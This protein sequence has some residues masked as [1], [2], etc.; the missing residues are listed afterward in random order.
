[1]KKI[2]SILLVLVSFFASA[3]KY[4]KIST[5]YEYNRFKV[6]GAFGIPKVMP[7]ALDTAD[8][9]PIYFDPSDSTI[10]VYYGGAWV[11]M[12]G[13]GT[14]TIIDT[15][16]G[17]SDTIVIG[18]GSS[19]V[20][21]VFGR[22][23]AISAQAGDYTFAQIGSRPTTLAGYG[24]TDPVV[25]TAGTYSNPSWL[26]GLHV[27]KL[28]GFSGT[29]NSGT[30]LYGDF[31]FRDP[32]S[33]GSPALV[34]MADGQNSTAEG[35][36]TTTTPFRI[37]VKHFA[38]SLY[39]K[40]GTDSIY[41]RYA[42]VD[43]FMFLSGGGAVDSTDITAPGVNGSVLI[44]VAGAVGSDNGLSYDTAK[45]LL[46]PDSINTK[47]V[48]SL[49]LNVYGPT[50]FNPPNSGIPGF[51]FPLSPALEISSL[52]SPGNADA[53]NDLSARILIK[54]IPASN[55]STTRRGISLGYYQQLNPSNP[56]K[57]GGIILSEGRSGLEIWGTH[58]PL[59]G[60]G[61]SKRMMLIDSTSWLH[62]GLAG[63]GNS[64][65]GVDQVGRAK[66]ISPT[67]LKVINDVDYTVIDSITH[68]R[69][70]ST[71]T[72]NRT[73]TLPSAALA[74]NHLIQIYLRDPGGFALQVTTVSGS[75]YVTAATSETL[76][77]SLNTVKTLRFMSDGTNW[78]SVSD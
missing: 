51:D 14:T 15:T 18:G 72:A 68:V 37:N 16:G 23:G 35:L 4:Q 57:G 5:W 60:F 8:A 50:I 19:P 24:I 10:K 41:M 36:G 20:T 47:K 71:L 11:K 78:Y 7:P 25:T 26:T 44:N 9:V 27:S 73:I 12:G 64:F 67:N 74:P 39:K 45:N 65:V 56:F 3:Q 6:T 76:P 63:T 31:V 17:G 46:I 30:V 13:G 61:S 70:N 1:M 53:V 77:Y 38:D 42:G 49:A 54:G 29:Q 58:G 55:T 43:R 33:S 40:P 32:L 21:N 69:Y 66:R 62:P 52:G 75:L 22:I 28:L 34:A 2:F 48:S 59:A